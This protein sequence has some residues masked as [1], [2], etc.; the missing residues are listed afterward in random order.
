METTSSPELNHSQAFPSEAETI[1]QMLPSLDGQRVE[2]ADETTAEDDIIDI[3]VLVH[4]ESLTEGEQQIIIEAEWRAQAS[5]QLASAWWNSDLMLG[6]HDYR[7]DIDETRQAPR[8]AEP[9]AIRRA[10]EFIAGDDRDRDGYYQVI[11]I[12]QQADGQLT[13][14][15]LDAIETTLT[16]IDQFTGGA[17]G[18]D[19]NARRILVYGDNNLKTNAFANR[20]GTVL[21]LAGIRQT[22]LE[23]DIDTEVLLSVVLA[24][25]VLGHQSDRLASS[26]SGIMREFANHFRYEGPVQY[27]GANGVVYDS[28]EQ[29]TPMVDNAESTGPVRAYGG[30]NPRE[31]LATTAE[32]IVT[33]TLG[34]DR[35]MQRSE[36]F[37]TT[38]DD[39]RD[40]L[41][42]SLFDRIARSAQ[43]VVEQ[44]TS[45]VGVGSPIVRHQTP[46]GVTYV[47][48]RQ[49]ERQTIDSQVFIDR[50]INMVAERLSAKLSD[51]KVRFVSAGIDDFN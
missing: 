50:E 42:L 23:E 35:Q 1:D 44:D 31:D 37:R 32:S 14:A 45:Y 12:G 16:Q 21:N 2:I 20:D 11:E 36:K 48:G 27:T 51:K 47:N 33:R 8:Y 43:Q 10:H 38:P 34:L 9:L 13:S 29:V 49:L 22:A 5:M 41:M 46:E 30:A 40:Q 15:E 24:H 18:H 39:Y 3:A 19:E 28:H 25:E 4:P 26:G 17:I 6:I 7:T